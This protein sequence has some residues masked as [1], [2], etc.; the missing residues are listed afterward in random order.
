M[1]LSHNDLRQPH[2][3]PN[4]VGEAESFFSFLDSALLLFE[5]ENA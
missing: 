3:F 5:N 2:V 4:I 1:G